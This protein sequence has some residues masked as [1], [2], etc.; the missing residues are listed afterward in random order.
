MKTKPIIVFVAAVVSV[1]AII[2]PGDSARAGQLD[3]KCF[4]ECNKTYKACTASCGTNTTCVNGCIATF[5]QCT[6]GCSK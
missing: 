2:A 5:R 1:F 4:A 6:S 3:P